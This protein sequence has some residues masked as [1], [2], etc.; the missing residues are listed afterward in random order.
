MSNSEG[1]VMVFRVKD[2]KIKEN[3]NSNKCSYTT[4][5][6][7]LVQNSTTYFFFEQDNITSI[8]KCS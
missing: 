7:R 2:R 6:K 5:L 4:S 3:K 1:T 8:E